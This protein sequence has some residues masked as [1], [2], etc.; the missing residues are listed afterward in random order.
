MSSAGSI[1]D[2]HAARKLEPGRSQ[3]HP[4]TP[5]RELTDSGVVAGAKRTTAP[6]PRRC[7]LCGA[8]DVVHNLEGHYDATGE[9]VVEHSVTIQVKFLKSRDQFRGWELQRGWKYKVFQGR[10]AMERNIC[11]P[12]LIGSQLMNKEFER[13]KDQELRSK[14]SSDSYYATLCEE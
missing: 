3:L 8:E 11:R 1:Y 14:N 9:A 12:C 6:A 10:P 4:T 13:K 5:L 7:A 2:Q